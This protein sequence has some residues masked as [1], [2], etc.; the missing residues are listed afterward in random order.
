MLPTTTP[1]T[2]SLPPPPP[3]VANMI[4]LHL[5]QALATLYPDYTTLSFLNLSSPFITTFASSP[6]SLPTFT[7][8]LTA[9]QPDSVPAPPDST[10]QA[11]A[12]PSMTPASSADN[13]QSKS[14]I[15]WVEGQED[16]SFLQED[17][18]EFDDGRVTLV[19]ALASLAAATEKFLKEGG[20][21]A[22]STKEE[23]RRSRVGSSSSLSTVLEIVQEEEENGANGIEDQRETAADAPAVVSIV[24]VET[25]IATVAGVAQATDETSTLASPTTTA[26]TTEQPASP[27]ESYGQSN[28]VETTPQATDANMASASTTDNT[29][30]QVLEEASNGQSIP[31]ETHPT[32]AETSMT[33]ASTTNILYRP[34]SVK[35][36]ADTLATRPHILENMSEDNRNNALINWQ[37]LPGRLAKEEYDRRADIHTKRMKEEEA[38]T[39]PGSSTAIPPT[40][41]S[42]VA[43]TTIRLSKY[44][45]NNDGGQGS[46]N[47]ASTSSASPVSSSKVTNQII[48]S[49]NSSNRSSSHQVLPYNRCSPV[50]VK[51]KEKVRGGDRFVQKLEKLKQA[52]VGELAAEGK[53][54]EDVAKTMA[55]NEAASPEIQTKEEQPRPYKAGRRAKKVDSLFRLMRAAETELEQGGKTLRMMAAV[56]SCRY[57]RESIL[58]QPNNNDAEEAPARTTPTS[59]V[60]EPVFWHQ[61]VNQVHNADNNNETQASGADGNHGHS[62]TPTEDPETSAYVTSQDTATLTGVETKTEIDE[63]RPEE[64]ADVERIEMIEQIALAATEETEQSDGPDIQD[65]VRDGHNDNHSQIQPVFF[66]SISVAKN[67][68]ILKAKQRALWEEPEALA[69]LVELEEIRNEARALPAQIHDHGHLQQ[70][71]DNDSEVG[72]KEDRLGDKGL[73]TSATASPEGSPFQV[74]ATVENYMPTEGDTAQVVTNEGSEHGSTGRPKEGEVSS[75]GVVVIVEEEEGDATDDRLLQTS[76][77]S[78]VTARE[79]GHGL[80]TCA[81]FDFFLA[82]MGMATS[83]VF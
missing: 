76:I 83:K 9:L 25:T 41:T 32:A 68:E 34:A 43:D 5:A 58:H 29:S 44:N 37:A 72:L 8:T 79:H 78:R 19:D 56:T 38:S 42:A 47:A 51:G 61:I 39:S 35:E 12:I 22:W 20:N 65:Q 15:S 73:T 82:Q 57:H 2:F 33:T 59:S 27:E 54:L 55:Q 17:A 77:S 7:L 70:T 64:T 4:K 13:A 74:D 24:E 6:A 21:S 11:S 53:S 49:R 81:G 45:N 66:N 52:I 36:F 46:S 48:Y 16:L 26:L 63:F 69:P 67:L 30:E 60:G 3:R 31:V 71:P 1:T 14:D 28:S 40:I 23:D 80:I 18:I 50:S 62:P 10:G 75:D